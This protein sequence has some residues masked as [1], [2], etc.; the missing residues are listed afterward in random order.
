MST[1]PYDSSEV[2]RGMAV[3]TIRRI[4]SQRGID[5]P[6]AS[7]D[8]NDRLIELQRIA[9]QPDTPLPDDIAT[10]EL[11]KTISKVAALNHRIALE[12]ELARDLIP[13]AQAAVE[14]TTTRDSVSVVVDRLVEDFAD[15]AQDVRRVIGIA[16]MVDDSQLSSLSV[17]Q[18]AARQGLQ[19]ALA[20]LERAFTDRR[21]IA[22]A[23]SERLYVT[24]NQRSWGDLP[25]LAFILAPPPSGRT[26]IVVQFADRFQQ[27]KSLNK[28]DVVQR[29]TE[30]FALESR[31]VLQ[32]R[33]ARLGEGA[34]RI[35]IAE[36]WQTVR[37]EAQSRYDDGSVAEAVERGSEMWRVLTGSDA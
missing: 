21:D 6:V 35:G 33:L 22:A 28:M 23:M 10:P 27:M 34:Q 18:F 31:G 7:Q 19:T 16:P 25:I 5:L 26:E 1:I 17:D 14:D 24:N 13:A 11:Q 8:A 36:S 4:A 2:L 3:Q 9:N 20:H 37:W 12:R 29:W 15:A 30:I 32:V